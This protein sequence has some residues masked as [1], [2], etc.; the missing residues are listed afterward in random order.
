MSRIFSPC[1]FN[2]KYTRNKLIKIHI[3]KAYIYT[4]KISPA[5]SAGSKDPEVE[6]LDITP[7]MEKVVRD[8]LAFAVSCVELKLIF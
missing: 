3:P 8:A 6:F 4:S 5:P 2:P 7:A 1:Q